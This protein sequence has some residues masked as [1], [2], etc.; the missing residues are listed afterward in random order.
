MNKN[1]TMPLMGY[2]LAINYIHIKERLNKTSSMLVKT[3]ESI[4]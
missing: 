3:L 2:S 4:R 1:N